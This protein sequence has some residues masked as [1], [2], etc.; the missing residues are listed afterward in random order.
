MLG[1]GADFIGA[2]FIGGNK[3]LWREQHWTVRIL[4]QLRIFDASDIKLTIPL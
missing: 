1:L 4:E 2:D 3:W